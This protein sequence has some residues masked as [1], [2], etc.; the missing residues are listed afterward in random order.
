M[1]AF[2][3]KIAGIN[4]EG[5]QKY[6]HFCTLGMPL[7]LKPEPENP[8]DPNA[9]GVWIK[10]TALFFFTAEVQLGYLPA[11]IAK[12]ISGH[13]KRGGAVR[14]EIS[15]ITGGTKGKPTRGVNILIHKET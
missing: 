5:R 2:H 7:I 10:A 6:I 3:T 8:Y 12:E 11:E 9:I 1:S 13:L 4:Q 14:G 15:S